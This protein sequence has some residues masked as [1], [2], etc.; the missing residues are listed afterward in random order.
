MLGKL[1]LASA[2]V[3]SLAY[4]NTSSGN[5]VAV[6]NMQ[7]AIQSTATGKKAKKELEAEFK[8]R[9]AELEKKEKD[10][11]KMSDDLEKKKSVLSEEVLAK[12][13]AELQEQMMKYRETLNKN[14][15]EIQKKEQDLTR[16]I[17]EKMKNV[18]AETA[19]AG[20]YSMVIEESAG[21]LYADP[22]TDITDAVVK[23]FEKAK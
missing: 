14:Q 5:K 17:L 13:Q 3:G 1:I 2:L 7:K 16:P 8:K 12:K 6:V 19:K 11:K 15:M 23:A 21:V 4:A 9:K 22:S 10:L 18:I 20:G